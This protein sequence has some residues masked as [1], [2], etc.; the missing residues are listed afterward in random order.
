MAVGAAIGVVS[1]IIGLYVSF[2]WGIA[3]GAAVVLV[4]IAIFLLALLIAPRRGVIRH[5][6]GR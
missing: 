1:G 4:S 5:L 2:Y 3:S 6:L